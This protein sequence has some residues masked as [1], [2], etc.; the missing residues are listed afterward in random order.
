MKPL[1]ATIPQKQLI[2]RLKRQKN[3]EEDVY[4]QMIS[5]FSN[6]RTFTSSELYK[7]EAQNL[8]SA[9]IGDTEEQKKRQEAA[10]RIVS[11]IYW[12]GLQIGCLNKDYESSAPEEMEMNKAKLNTFL[13]SRGAIKK[14][15][16]KQ[17]MEELKET[18]RQLEKM[19]R[20]EEA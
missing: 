1:L 6:G 18:L 7:Y 16:S 14:D 12:L 19:A 5:D 20:K 9:L 15:I 13:R 8:I 17:N 11:R 10:R 2:H 4:R 3:I